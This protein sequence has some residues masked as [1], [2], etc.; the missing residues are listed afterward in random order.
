MV[1]FVARVYKRHNIYYVGS[2]DYVFLT[3]ICAA[4]AK[5]SNACCMLQVSLSI[6]M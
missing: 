1:L 5:T 6:D 3:F 4:R 2:D